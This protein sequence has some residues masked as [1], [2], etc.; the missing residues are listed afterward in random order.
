MQENEIITEN[1]ALAEEAI[2][3]EAETVEAKGESVEISEPALADEGETES[4]TEEA[5]SSEET[6]E[7]EDTDKDAPA[8]SIESLRE[9]IVTLKRL[10]AEREQERDR[11]MV[12]LSEF[13]AVYPDKSLESVPEEVW[14]S[15]K[16]GVPLAA[17]YALYE[18]KTALHNEFAKEVNSR[19]AE[20]SSG[21]VGRE[22]DCLYYSPDE[23]RQMSASE[24]REKYNIIIES[25]KKWN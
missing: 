2:E 1:E 10:I 13:S 6:V 17:A 25:M 18:R 22:C 3:V 7:V 19:N 9:E 15:V 8:D 4:V 16:C 21:A 24:V 11:M 20:R 12:Q 5:E 14:S 23:V